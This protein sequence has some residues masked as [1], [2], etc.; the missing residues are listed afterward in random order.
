MNSVL[1]QSESG[2]SDPDN[3]AHGWVTVSG[4]DTIPD[5]VGHRGDGGGLAQHGDEAG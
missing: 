3:K 2:S 1:N 4:V 5:V